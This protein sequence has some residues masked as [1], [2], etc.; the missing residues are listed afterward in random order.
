[1]RPTI[2]R[3]PVLYP[4]EHAKNSKNHMMLW[5]A[6]CGIRLA[7]IELLVYNSSCIFSF[8]SKAVEAGTSGPEPF[9]VGRE[10]L[11]LQMEMGLTGL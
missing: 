1:M 2:S 8:A 6:G 10:R 11:V 7:K 9:W 5:G 4:K 3:F